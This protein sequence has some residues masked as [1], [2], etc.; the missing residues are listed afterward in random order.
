MEQ[1]LLEN[2]FKPYGPFPEN[3]ECFRMY[4]G[5]V[6]CFKVDVVD[7]RDGTYNIHL[8]NKRSESMGNLLVDDYEQM[9]RFITFAEE[10]YRDRAKKRKMSNGKKTEK[11]EGK[12]D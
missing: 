1:E 10:L 2:G 8:D 6:K 11:E 9:M 4:K 12:Q 7:F 3:T 5:S